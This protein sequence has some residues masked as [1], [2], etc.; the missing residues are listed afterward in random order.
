[1]GG[2]WVR[3]AFLVP[4]GAALLAIPVELGLAGRLPGGA[5]DIVIDVAWYVTGAFAFIAASRNRA[6][7][8]LLAAM[9]IALLGKAVGYSPLAHPG[10][11][12]AVI[13][14]VEAL[15]WLALW[16]ALGAFAVFPN[17]IYQRRH[18]RWLVV[19]ALPIAVPLLLVQLVG[20]DTLA[21]HQ[22]VWVAIRA[23]NPFY[24]GQLHTLAVAAQALVNNGNSVLLLVGLSLLIL[25]Y[26]RFGP[27]QRRQIRWPLYSIGLTLLSLELLYFLPRSTEPYPPAEIAA[28]TAVNSLLPIGMAIGILNY[29]ALDIDAVIRRSVVF[30][31][32]WLSIAVA[33]VSLA[34]AFGIA[35]GQ[36][37]PLGLAVLLTIIATLL[38]Q[39]GRR[40]LE[41]LADRVVFGQRLNGY[42]L[43]SQLG[44]RLESSAAT[45][46]VAGTVAATV[47]SGLGARW[48]RVK[49]NDPDPRPV[50]AVG[51][52]PREVAHASLSAPLI[53]AELVVGRIEC[54]PKLD[55][56][57]N[58]SDQ[59]LL[60]M[61][62]RQAALSIRNSQ[63]T[64]ELS[65]RLEELGASRVRLVQ[66]DD[67]ARRRL[68]RDLH[69][70][71]QQQ[72]VGLLAR[73]GLARNQL[74]R[75]AS[76]TEATL[77][78]A[79]VD[80]QR[81]LESV[82]ELARGIHPAI[83]TDRGLIEAVKERATRMT[84]PVEVDTSGVPVD[85]RFSAELEGAAYFFVSEALANVIKH[86]DATRVQVHFHTD[87]GRLVVDVEDDGSGFDAG[88]VKQSGLRGLRDRIEAQGGQVELASRPGKGTAL[89]MILPVARAHA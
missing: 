38:F 66:A 58:S 83:L 88:A 51:I 47:Q 60:T 25:R 28:W 45:K 3:L 14:L 6:A 40:R 34:A 48:V 53:H 41:R 52:L 74:R 44:A 37:V 27:E 35:V 43:I 84:V 1:M 24:L 16:C 73:L 78:E 42:E 33:Y 69:D 68:E 11:G 89:K 63:L 87:L 82:Q 77:R 10:S 81:V 79:Q 26:R 39:P 75:D 30:G 2:R 4:G 62:G 22:L 64:A 86:A 15:S 19:A 55:G 61:L 18:E 80:A 72:L 46:D 20:L 5:N 85:A 56:G 29:R 67:A 17:G 23:P 8:W 76:V 13:V 57:Y 65:D 32:L 70:G 36:R 7:K 31:A 54:G 50:A 9:S 59:A 21:T 49:L 71:V 12:W